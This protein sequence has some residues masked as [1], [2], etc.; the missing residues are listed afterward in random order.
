M[1][2]RIAIVDTSNPRDSKS[3]AESL[4]RRL[5]Q[6]LPAESAPIG[7]SWEGVGC[8][9]EDIRDHID[10]FWL[11][12][13]HDSPAGSDLEM[14]IE[15]AVEQERSG[16]KA[17]PA[18]IVCYGGGFVRYRF[19][20]ENPS[21]E[22][23]A[24]NER[25]LRTHKLEGQEILTFDE[26][27]GSQWNFTGFLR[28]VADSYPRVNAAKLLAILCGV[29]EEGGPSYRGITHSVMTVVRLLQGE[30]RDAIDG[31]ASARDSFL[32]KAATIIR[33]I[34]N[35]IDTSDKVEVPRE[36]ASV[37]QSVVRDLG[38]MKESVELLQTSA[39][40]SSINRD[41]NDLL[42]KSLIVSCEAL[43]SNDRG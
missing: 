16:R 31:C 23:L 25:M 29:T 7:L 19:P 33:A 2:K 14:T 20:P 35:I 3:R 11:V 22:Q 27:P 42:L 32:T 30:M 34:D 6:D 9:P 28:A 38:K 12:W 24:V 1:V 10:D 26:E 43:R 36:I 4:L 18:I 13:A 8:S 21:V 40:W 37:F 39:N 41:E 15:A 5:G 17:L